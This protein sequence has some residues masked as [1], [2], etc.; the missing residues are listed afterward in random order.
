MFKKFVALG[1]VLAIGATVAG[2][3]SSPSSSSSSSH[4]KT[5]TIAIAWVNWSEDVAATH[6]W[7]QILTK[8]GYKVKLVNAS[9]APVYEGVGQGS[10]SLYMDAWLPHTQGTYWNRIKSKAVKISSWYTSATKEGFVVPDYVSINSISQLKSHSSL[11]N[12]QIV[13]IDPGAGEMA[14]AQKAVKAYGLPEHLITSSSSAMLASLSKAESQHKPVVVT[15]WSPH[16]AF[17]KWHLKY[18]S[19]PK[20]I[21]GPADHIYT[22]AN[23]SFPSQHPT[24][25]KWLK[26]FH[27][28][29]T[30]VGQLENDINAVPSSQ[31][32][33]AINK[34]ISQNK[35]LVNSW[36]K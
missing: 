36:T 18:L 14:L 20:N 1:S 28:N 10:I 7:D 17:A 35:S 13:G 25:T 19:D 6:L 15:L 33:S 5:I 26:N 24:V 3:G 4:S 16:W 27:M 31:I 9:I 22:I 23:K 30:Q 34:W 8:K 29:Q 12:N 21:F 32:N 2:C 11:F